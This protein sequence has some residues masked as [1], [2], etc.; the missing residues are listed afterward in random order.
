MVNVVAADTDPAGMVTVKRPSG[1]TIAPPLASILC[2]DGAPTATPTAVA[3]AV[4]LQSTVTF[5]MLLLPMVPLPLA[6][7]QACGGFVGWVLTVTAKAPLASGVANVNGPLAPMV[8][9]SPPLFCSAR[10][11]PLNPVTVPPTVWGVGIASRIL[12][13]APAPQ[14][15]V[16][17]AISATAAKRSL[18]DTR[19]AKRSANITPGKRLMTHPVRCKT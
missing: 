10:P 14:P 9:S 12:F 11:D 13:S 8:R 17:P 1:D 16:K 3:T 7:A 18:F 2:E 15:T 5:V 19:C 6:I 4:R